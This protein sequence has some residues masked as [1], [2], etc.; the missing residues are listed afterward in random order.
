MRKLK[1]RENPRTRC[2]PLSLRLYLITH[3]CVYHLCRTVSAEDKRPNYEALAILA[4]SRTFPDNRC[5]IPSSKTAVL[6]L[7]IETSLWGLMTASRGL[8]AEILHIKYLHYRS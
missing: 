3:V 8:I 7:W 4:L 2:S 1:L 5:I 6:N